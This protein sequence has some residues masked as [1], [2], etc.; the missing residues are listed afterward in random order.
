MP[1]PS[2]DVTEQKH[3]K[4]EY[5]TSFVRSVNFGTRAEPGRASFL[6]TWICSERLGAD[7]ILTKKGAH[8]VALHAGTPRHFTDVAV[9]V[10]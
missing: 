1:H 8:M 2:S 5:L 3:Q 10:A 6:G 4:C 9:C 7:V